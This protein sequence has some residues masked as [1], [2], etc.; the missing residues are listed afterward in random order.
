MAPIRDAIV[1]VAGL[2]TRLL[3]ATRSVPKEMLPVVDR[4]VVQY[5]IEELAAAG[6]T[7]V[8]MVTGRRKRAIEDHFDAD[9]ELGSDAIPGEGMRLL[10]TRQ[11]RPAGLGDAVARGAGFATAGAPGVVVALGDAIIEPPPSGD[12]GIV[13]ALIEAHARHGATATLAVA[14]VPAQDVGRYGIVSG[15]PIG[16]DP[17]TL[18]VTRL[19]EK[20]APE[21]A[22]G[23]LAVAARYVLGPDVFAAL[24]S[25]TPDA[26]G[27]L[28]L[29]DA[30]ATVL[31]A[32]G[33][34]IAVPLAPGEHRHDIGSVQG[35]CR[36]FLRYAMSHP[37]LGPS[38][39]AE[40][41]ALLD[42]PGAL[43]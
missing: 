37:E 30:L 33:R 10:Y 15:E 23:R 2:G 1:P 34:V 3:P 19:V 17:R 38:L 7:R 5:V 42:D 29:T 41:A 32:G 4:P 12:P 25:I 28:Q 13:A 22:P 36:T 27:E 31:A 11:P 40:A 39:R 8:L 35:Y 26:S 18:Q 24:R 14:E 9:A 6:I 16:D 43:A 21:R 20:P